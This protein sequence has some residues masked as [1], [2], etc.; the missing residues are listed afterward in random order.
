MQPPLVRLRLRDFCWIPA[1]ADKDVRDW[2]GKS[3]LF[4]AAMNGHT[5]ITCLLV[6]ARAD[7][8]DLFGKSALVDA[9]CNGHVKIAL[10]LDAGADKDVR[11]EMASVL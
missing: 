11:D 2:F 6:D 1:G 7:K 5:E 10:L 3:A 4:L 9:L 8:G